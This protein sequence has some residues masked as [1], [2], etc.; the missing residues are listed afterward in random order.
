MQQL[1]NPISTLNAQNVP[2]V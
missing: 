2:K 1:N